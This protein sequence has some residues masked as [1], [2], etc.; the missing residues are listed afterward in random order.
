MSKPIQILRF[1]VFCL[2]VLFSVLL[3]LFISLFSIFSLEFQKEEYGDSF[4]QLC[5]ILI[6]TIILSTI[7]WRI[8]RENSKT[9]N[10]SIVWSTIAIATI[11][12]LLLLLLK[13][14]ISFGGWS[15]EVI[16]FR[17][18]KTQYISI[19]KQIWDVGALGYDRERTRIVEL[20]PLLKYFYVVK[21][22]DTSE[23][24][25]SEWNLVNEEGDIH[26]P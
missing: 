23:L 16:L 17:N 15:N 21:A 1:T 8:K 12:L 14:K 10:Q 19:N 13:L 18:A 7:F 22:V 6:P 26:F 2:T 9:R 11:S 5:I 20:K 24:D 25:K 4:F 3:I